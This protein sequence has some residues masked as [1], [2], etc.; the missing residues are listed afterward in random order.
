MVRTKKGAQA[1]LRR[2]CGWKSFLFPRY[3]RIQHA[4]EAVEFGPRSC[5]GG[6]HGV[7]DPSNG[8]VRSEIGSAQVCSRRIVPSNRLRF[9]LTL[10]RRTDNR[11]AISGRRETAIAKGINMVILWLSG[12]LESVLGYIAGLFRGY[13]P[14][15]ERIFSIVP[16]SWSLAARISPL[17][18]MPLPPE[19]SVT[20]PPASRTRTIP[21]AMSQG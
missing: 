2:W 1:P 20:K 12:G 14:A 3:C 16:C 18:I 6:H 10:G 13:F 4:L 15:P 5:H 11:F 17:S 21:A 9:T 7:P 19:R 8:V